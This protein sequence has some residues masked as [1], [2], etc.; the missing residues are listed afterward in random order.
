MR[1]AGDATVLEIAVKE[2][3]GMREAGAMTVLE[4]AV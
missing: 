1:E 2:R 4:I 3:G